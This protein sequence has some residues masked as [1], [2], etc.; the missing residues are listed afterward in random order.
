MVLIAIDPYPHDATRL[1]ST[2]NLEVDCQIHTQFS[3]KY[4]DGHMTMEGYQ[5]LK[6]CLKH[7]LKWQQFPSPG[8]THHP[9][10]VATETQIAKVEIGQIT[11]QM[12]R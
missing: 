10:S 2:W 4:L 1:P 5:V 11:R 6:E 9:N 3:N 7:L 12:Q 8:N